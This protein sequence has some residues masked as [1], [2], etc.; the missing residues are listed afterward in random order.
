MKALRPAAELVSDIG[1]LGFDLQH[2]STA[3][4]ADAVTFLRT[5]NPEMFDW[6]SRLLGAPRTLAAVDPVDGTGQEGATREKSS[7]SENSGARLGP[8]GPPDGQ[9]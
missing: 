4:I 7:S 2:H 5:V 3:D 9:T 8:A 1:S 6:L